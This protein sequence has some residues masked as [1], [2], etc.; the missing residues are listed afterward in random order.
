[1]AVHLPAEWGKA[2]PAC[3][4]P[5]TGDEVIINPSQ[6]EEV[7]CPACA[8]AVIALTL[9]DRPKVGC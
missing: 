4:L 6:V 2:A 7:T 3:G 1:M 5:W 9:S 8:R